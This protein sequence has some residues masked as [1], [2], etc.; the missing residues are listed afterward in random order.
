GLFGNF[1]LLFNANEEELYR[2]RVFSSEMINQFKEIKKEESLIEDYIISICEKENINIIPLYSE[3]YP[4]NLKNLPDAPLFFYAQGDLN[5][6]KGKK[7]AIVGSRK[8]EESALNWAKKL[9]EDLVKE[10]IT[11]VSGGAIGI[12]SQA[13][14]GALGFQGKTICVLGS[15]LLR[16]Y[17]P[18]NKN[19]FEEIKKKGLLISEHP[20]TDKGGILS[21]LRRNRI[22]S[23]ISDSI[24]IVTSAKVGGSR[25]QIEIANKQR[26]PSF[27]PKLSLNLKPNEGIEEA[28]S[29]HRINE[30]E[31]YKEVL[32]TIQGKK[33]DFSIQKKLLS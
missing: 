16:L 13:H 5:L 2:T 27:V 6:L 23:G 8:S 31:D 11:I 21:L 15:G 19:L 24:V 9:S 18:V 22:I 14:L 4:S 26:I 10:S 17:P 3:D 30:I 33:D 20:P 1:K 29:L 28:I 32:K 12:D 25:T 7:V